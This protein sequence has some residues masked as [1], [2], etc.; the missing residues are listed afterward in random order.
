MARWLEWIHKQTNTQRHKRHRDTETQRHRETR[1]T[2]PS[3]RLDSRAMAIKINNA[4][5]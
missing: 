4:K 2:H 1:H 3:T 5:G